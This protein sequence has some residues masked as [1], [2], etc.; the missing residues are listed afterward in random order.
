LS[1]KEIVSVPKKKVIPKKF[2]LKKQLKLF[3]SFLESESELKES[4]DE[5]FDI[6]SNFPEQSP[7]VNFIRSS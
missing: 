3:V 7:L 1:D 4:K 5:N 2:V 6:E